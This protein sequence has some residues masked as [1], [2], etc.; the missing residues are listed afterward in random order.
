MQG[1]DRGLL[2][3]EGHLG[4]LCTR[5]CSLLGRGGAAGAHPPTL[6]PEES[7]VNVKFNPLLFQVEELRPERGSNSSWSQR[8]LV[9]DIGLTLTAPPGGLAS[10]LFHS[11]PPAF[12]F[13]SSP[14]NLSPVPLGPGHCHSEQTLRAACFSLHTLSLPQTLLLLYSSPCPRCPHTNEIKMSGDGVQ[15]PVYFKDP[16][17]FSF[18]AG[19]GNHWVSFH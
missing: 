7:S 8:K 9:T 17:V 12:P 3:Q 11:C 19:F 16:G 5:R 18:T 10:L 4:L 14:A 15:A 13:H 6:E 2:N 1:G